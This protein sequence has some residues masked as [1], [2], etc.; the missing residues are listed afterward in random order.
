MVLLECMRKR[1]TEG[2]KDIYVKIE[3]LVL[4]TCVNIID[5][6]EE[7]RKNVIKQLKDFYD[8]AELRTADI[9]PSIEVMIAQM[10][11]LKQS[12]NFESYMD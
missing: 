1:E 10:Y 2:N 3:Q 9:V 12:S 11:C 7:F 4:E 6:H 5:F 8:S